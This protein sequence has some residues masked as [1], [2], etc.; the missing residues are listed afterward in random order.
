MKFY[1]EY[2]N[3]LQLDSVLGIS[4]FSWA[5]Y[6]EGNLESI[7]RRVGSLS[8]VVVNLLQLLHTKGIQL[9][10]DDVNFLS[11]GTSGYKTVER[12]DV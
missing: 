11:S 7:E 5:R 2:G 12:V 4:D 10:C 3:E 6:D 8:A 9:S 1:D